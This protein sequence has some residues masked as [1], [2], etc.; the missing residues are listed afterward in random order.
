M[1]LGLQ[2]SRWTLKLPLQADL[3]DS[4]FVSHS[5]ATKMPGI[6][7]T[8]RGRASSTWK[9]GPRTHFLFDTGGH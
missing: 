4:E 1:G 5:L 7:S 8:Y 6:L 3:K 2:C 9:R